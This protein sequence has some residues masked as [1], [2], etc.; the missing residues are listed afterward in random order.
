MHYE[1]L[2]LVNP[3]E[4]FKKA[5]TG[6][7]A[8]PAFN[9]VSI[10][11]IN[12]I[13]DACIEKK[14]PL[15]LIVSPNLIRQIEP[16]TISYLVKANIERA[17]RLGIDIPV[18]LFL[19]H[20]M[21]YE[22][23]V[24]AIENGF[25]AVMIDG[26]AL[27]FEENIELT[28]KVV[29]YANKQSVSV[30]AELGALSGIEEQSANS[31]DIKHSNIY[32]DSKKA[33]I[34]IKETGIDCLAVSVGTSHGL[35]KVNYSDIKKESIIRY[36]ILEDIDSRM[37]GFPLVLHGAST[38]D[39]KVINILNKYGGNVKNAQGIPEEEISKVSKTAICKINIASDG[40][41]TALA[42]TRKILHENPTAIDPRIYT[43][44]IRKELQKLYLHKISIFGSEGKI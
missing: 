31:N 40:W 41:I 23:C 13:F 11:Q 22:D 24:Y 32:T 12:G 21:R 42:Y 4:M 6:K 27:S 3:K 16:E 38:L 36:D 8:I 35:V 29:K 15:I 39:I 30:E 33:E 1:E 25:S 18:S 2:G 10:E 5:Y 9:F 19:D 17:K 28:N 34:F 20:G 26:S 37:K 14:S 44:P 7:Y 43:L